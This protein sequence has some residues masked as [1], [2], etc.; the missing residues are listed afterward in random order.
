MRRTNF[1]FI[2]P[3]ATYSAVRLPTGTCG[4]I[5]GYANF[6]PVDL[7]SSPEHE[8]PSKSPYMRILFALRQKVWQEARSFDYTSRGR[9]IR[10]PATNSTGQLIL[11]SQRRRLNRTHASGSEALKHEYC[12]PKEA[13]RRE[14]RLFMMEDENTVPNMQARLMNSER[15]C[16]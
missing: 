2:V 14:S 12:G 1:P 11:S 4:P 6:N 10:R 16:V 9:Y 5:C 8:K 3:V 13:A 7:L 15:R